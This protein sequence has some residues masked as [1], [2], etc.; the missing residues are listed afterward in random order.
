MAQA[1]GHC[2]NQWAALN[3]FAADGGVPIDN[4]ASEREMRRIA[5]NRR[6]SL[7]VGSERGGRT[8]AVLSSIPSACRRHDVDPRRHLTQLPANLPG[9]PLSQLDRWLPDHWK[10]NQP[11][12]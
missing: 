2:L 9:T 1:V 10:L 12:M 6:N 3:V 8:A 11:A 4:D 5:L 7:F